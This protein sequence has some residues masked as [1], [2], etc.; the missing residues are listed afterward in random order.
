[1]SARPVVHRRPPDIVDE[2]VGLLADY[3][4]VQKR[5]TCLFASQAAEIERLQAEAMRLRAAV[6]MRDTALAAV[7]DELLRNAAAGGALFRT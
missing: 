1:M 2:Y 6:I 5:C 4:A 3:G 7:R